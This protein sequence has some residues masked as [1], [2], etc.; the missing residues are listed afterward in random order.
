M[1]VP[2]PVGPSSFFFFFFFFTQQRLDPA[3]GRGHWR[4]TSSGIHSI[5]EFLGLE[6][7]GPLGGACPRLAAPPLGSWMTPSA[8]LGGWGAASWF[9]NVITRF[10]DGKSIQGMLK[11]EGFLCGPKGR[12]EA[13]ED[14][15]RGTG[16]RDIPCEPRHLEN[17]ATVLYQEFSP[18]P[19]A[20]HS[21][22]TSS[23]ARERNCSVF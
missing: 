17:N 10:H 22:N 6:S 4:L 21:I 9:L 12:V 20:A 3:T 11:T 19:F 1:D 18:T 5:G 14:Q 13:E 2:L 15:N 23:E 16:G 8:S 7:S